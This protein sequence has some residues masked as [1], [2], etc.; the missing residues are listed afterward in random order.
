MAMS[1]VTCDSTPDG[2]S[3]SSCRTPSGSLK[4]TKNALSRLWGT[5]QSMAFAVSG[6]TSYPA[7]RNWAMTILATR[8][9][10]EVSIDMMPGTF[11][12]TKK[13]GRS[14]RTHLANSMKSE[15]R[16]SL[17]SRVP[18]RENAWQGGPPTTP[19]GSSSSSDAICVQSSIS[20][21]S[22]RT[23]ATPGWLAP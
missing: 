15:H 11:S 16:G 10:D 18:Q 9:P 7:S 17:G 13:S 14:W 22:M 5:P 6:K 1:T 4:P 2:S 20:R 3:T 12:I 19:T 23:T 8:S 21:A